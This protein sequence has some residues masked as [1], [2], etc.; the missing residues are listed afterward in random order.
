ME[1]VSDIHYIDCFQMK[2]DQVSSLNGANGKTGA[3]QTASVP[4]GSIAHSNSQSVAGSA[5]SLLDAA[6]R[7][8]RA[9]KAADERMKKRL[10]EAHQ[11]KVNVL[12]MNLSSDETSLVEFRC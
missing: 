12:R 3:M 8:I 2:L 9:F 11:E 1:R 7:R 10:T 4:K 6:D 5:K